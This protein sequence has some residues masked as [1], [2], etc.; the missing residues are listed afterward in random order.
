MA[1]MQNIKPQFLPHVH[2]LYDSILK[3]QLLF[4]T[5]MLNIYNL[6]VYC[7][8]IYII[9]NVIVKTSK[10]PLYGHCQEA[11]EASADFSATIWGSSRRLE[12][13]ALVP[14][15]LTQPMRKTNCSHLCFKNKKKKTI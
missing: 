15:A 12:A 13:S 1:F 11:S 10:W 6:C 5:T 14:N 2:S 9:L 7:I 3:T 8:Y 4:R